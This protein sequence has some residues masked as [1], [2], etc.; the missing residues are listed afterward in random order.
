VRS[1][2]SSSGRSIVIDAR[3]R[4]VRLGKAHV[5]VNPGELGERSDTVF[6]SL[7]VVSKLLGVDAVYDE[8]GAIVELRGVESLPIA[9]A[10]RR[11]AIKEAR[12]AA[13]KT[14]SVVPHTMSRGGVALEYDL[15]V[16]SQVGN[17]LSRSAAI[18]ASGV[19]AVATS[20]AGGVASGR[21]VRGVATTLDDVSWTRSWATSRLLS[22]LRVGDVN[23]D[24]PRSE[25]VRGIAITNAPLAFDQV[26][27]RLSFGGSVP[28]GWQV[29]ALRGETLLDESIA[30]RG[31]YDLRVPVQRGTTVVDVVATSPE[32]EQRLFQRSLHTAPMFVAPGRLEYRAA[33][34]ACA[35]RFLDRTCRGAANADLRY[36]LAPGW[37]VRG[38][39]DL[40]SRDGASSSAP[41]PYAGLGGVIARALV[42]EGT[43]APN[44]G[45]SKATAAVAAR[46]EPSPALSIGADYSG[47]EV[48]AR[49][50]VADSET[51]LPDDLPLTIEYARGTRRSAWVRYVPSFWSRRVAI[52]ASASA[53]T[54]ALIQSV[55]QRVAMPIHLPSVQVMPF[56]RGDMNGSATLSTRR[57]ARTSVL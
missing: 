10:A 1:R 47:S 44:V 6:V 13:M 2:I 50:M 5:K 14:P 34:G 37:T 56:W 41:Q 49:A 38:G 48:V 31:G 39:V 51:T 28:D 46:F 54:V 29:E 3:R 36:G 57:D 55:S 25:L 8:A 21:V 18:E 23:I 7:R 27:T 4:S 9:A 53:Y 16:G 15:S 24:G 42:R 43:Y 45:S 40:R 12:A 20:I 35:G 30:R 52:D 11:L 22:E 32:G 19:V 26:A 33:A 17:Q